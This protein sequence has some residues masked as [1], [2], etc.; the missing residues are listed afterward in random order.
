MSFS[1]WKRVAADISV[2]DR[3]ARFILRMYLKVGNRAVTGKAA[4]CCCKFRSIRSAQAV[5][6]FDTFNGS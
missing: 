5:V 1:R 2:V 3:V 4:R 6:S